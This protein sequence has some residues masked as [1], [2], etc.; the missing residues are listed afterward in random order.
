MRGALAF[1]PVVALCCAGAAAAPRRRHRRRHRRA[2]SPAPGRQVQG[3][4]QGAPAGGED[5]APR[6]SKISPVVVGESGATLAE[7]EQD[8]TGRAAGSPLIVTWTPSSDEAVAQLDHQGR[9]R[10]RLLR[11]AHLFPW[12]VRHPARGCEL[13]DRLAD[14]DD[15]GGAQARGRLRQARRDRCAKDKDTAA[16]RLTLFIAGHTDTVGDSAYNLKLSRERARSIAPGSEARRS[17]PLAFEG[18]GETAPAVRPPTGRRA[19]QPPRRLHSF[20]RRAD[21]EDQRLQAGV[22]TDQLHAR[23]PRPRT[24]SSAVARALRSRRCGSSPPPPLAAPVV[25]PTRCDRGPYCVT[26]EVDDQFSVAVE[27]VKCIALLES[28]SRDGRLRRARRLLPG[29]PGD[30]C[31]VR[32]GSRRRA[33]TPS[34]SRCC[35]SAPVR[36]RR[37]T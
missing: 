33:S 8:F 3:R 9:R 27:G 23:A 31:R 12:F 36:R 37:S 4:P 29:W 21:D 26:G 7:E 10:P 18:F 13:Q 17:V 28:G 34:R 30:A 6:A 32:C 11:R 15:R 16:R 2:A 24:P 20:G 1:D 14:I 19:A 22:E 25:L 5:V 35:R